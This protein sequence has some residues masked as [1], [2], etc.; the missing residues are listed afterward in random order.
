MHIIFNNIF[1][2]PKISD[3][4][5]D[6][7]RGLGGAPQPM[8]HEINARL[9]YKKAKKLKPVPWSN[10]KSGLTRDNEPGP[11]HCSRQVLIIGD[12]T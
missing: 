1:W 11:S 8:G 10:V 12:I 4:D 6:A 7:R 9:T 2:Q 3:A 5:F